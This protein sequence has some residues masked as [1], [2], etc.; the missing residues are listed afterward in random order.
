MGKRLSILTLSSIVIG[1]MASAGRADEFDNRERALARA[2]TQTRDQ[3]EYLRDVSEI[4][5]LNRAVIEK[6]RSLA[7]SKGG[8]PKNVRCYSGV[9]FPGFARHITEESD[10]TWQMTNGVPVGTAI[11]HYS[12]GNVI[13]A[14]AF[15][16]YSIANSIRHAG[17]EKPVERPKPPLI[18]L[19]RFNVGGKYCSVARYVND[20]GMSAKCL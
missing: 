13:G 9:E 8:A 17:D 3:Q 11:P 14:I 2:E 6:V 19:C 18:G 15:S 20:G 16:P 1:L 7:H 4:K 5:D 10:Y 12:A